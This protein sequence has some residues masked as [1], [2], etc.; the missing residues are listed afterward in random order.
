[1]RFL[2]GCWNAPQ[3]IYTGADIGGNEQQVILP[4]DYYHF[5]RCIIFVHVTVPKIK[6]FAHRIILK[7]HKVGHFCPFMHGQIRLISS[8]Q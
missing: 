2:I 8:G 5:T 4:D 7:D 3:A 6:S 1:M